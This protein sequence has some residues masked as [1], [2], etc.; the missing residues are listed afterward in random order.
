MDGNPAPLKLPNEAVSWWHLLRQRSNEGLR[1]DEAGI[2]QSFWIGQALRRDVCG[3]GVRRYSDAAR[4]E[5]RAAHATVGALRSRGRAWTEPAAARTLRRPLRLGR[6]G[7]RGRGGQRGDVEELEGGVG[8]L[9]AADGGHCGRR[10]CEA[11]VGPA[12]RCHVTVSSGPARGGDLGPLVVSAGSVPQFVLVSFPRG[13]APAPHAFVAAAGG[14]PAGLRALQ[15][16]A[17]VCNLEVQED[18]A[19]GLSALG[20]PR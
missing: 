6:A 1:L 3:R 19:A 9:D 5:R 14:R 12:G 4:G 16:P 8:P 7:E 10:T 2:E 18:P 15:L 11:A 17:C 20:A 13:G